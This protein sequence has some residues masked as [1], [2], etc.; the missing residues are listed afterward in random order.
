MSENVRNLCMIDVT[1]ALL[2]LR[3]SSER[4]HPPVEN[5]IS[6]L[7]R[8]ALLCHDLSLEIKTLRKL[9]KDMQGK[10]IISMA[11]EVNAGSVILNTLMQHTHNASREAMIEV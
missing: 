1:C 5:T 6:D 7:L 11:L 9:F 10:K 8:S 2:L 4:T 3:P